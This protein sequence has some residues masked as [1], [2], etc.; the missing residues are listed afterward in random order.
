MQQ[1]PFDVYQENFHFFFNDTATT[2]IYT[3]SLHD[4]LPISL[5]SGDDAARSLRAPRRPARLG[6]PDA[7]C[8]DTPPA[9]SC[10]PVP[11]YL[12]ASASTRSPGSRTPAR[13]HSSWY[14]GA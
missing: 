4:A 7:A 8:R 12:P 10:R 11:G 14:P 1:E 2:E 6:S 3:L 9:A 13:T 5:R